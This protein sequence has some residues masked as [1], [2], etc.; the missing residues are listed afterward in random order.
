MSVF[1]VIIFIDYAKS[2]AEKRGNENCSSKSSF[3]QSGTTIEINQRTKYVIMN[4][5]IKYYFPQ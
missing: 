5:T 1:N 3:L 2:N 4:E